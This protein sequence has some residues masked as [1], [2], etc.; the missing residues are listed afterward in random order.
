[1]WIFV[2]S[3]TKLFLKFKFKLFWIEWQ[4]MKV[5]IINWIISKEHK[6]NYDLFAF[7]QL[8]SKSRILGIQSISINDK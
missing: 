8:Y 6:F 3:L 2:T 1:M 4:W 5:K 7:F